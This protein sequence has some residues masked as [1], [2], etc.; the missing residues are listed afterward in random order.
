MSFVLSIICYGIFLFPHFSQDTYSHVGANTSLSDYWHNSSIPQM[1]LGRYTYA[2]LRTIY[3]II[4][5]DSNPYGF[6]TNVFAIIIFAITVFYGYIILLNKN[7]KLIFKLLYFVSCCTIFYNPLFADWFQFAECVPFYSLGLLLTLFSVNI[8]YRRKIKYKF[9]LSLLVL[10]VSMGI[11]QPVII[12]FVIFSLILSWN[13]LLENYKI[14]KEINLKLLI[15]DIICSLGIYGIASVF[16][17]ILTKI[18][19]TSSRVNTDIIN[20]IKI[21]LNTQISLWLL[22]STGPKTYLFV[23]V[24]ILIVILGILVC[25][26]INSKIK[27]K[28]QLLFISIVFLIAIYIAIFASHIIAEAWLSQRTVTAFLGLTGYLIITIG[29]LIEIL[30]MDFR[31]ILIFSNI[32]IITLLIF[33]CYRTTNLGIDLIKVNAQDSQIVYMINDLIREYEI[34]SGYI[35]NK[36]AVAYDKNVTWGYTNT[37]YMYDL[38][39]RSWVKSWSIPGMFKLY[40]DRDL[41]LIDMPTNIYDKYFIDKNWNSFNSNQVYFDNDTIYVMIY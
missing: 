40:T 32:S 21:V 14:N 9:I 22:K 35:V 20:N 33:F 16:Q 26:N 2:L 7:T 11:Y 24:F 13:N 4:T 18:V 12:Y 39:I 28:I 10:I 30:D 38:N 36:I 8:L 17:F 6:V 34:E 15:K 25:F 5:G 19:S 27:I 23:I 3:L 37:T 41:K 31:N 1:K 29:K